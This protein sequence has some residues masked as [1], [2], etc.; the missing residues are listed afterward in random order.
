MSNEDVMKH[1]LVPLILFLRDMESK[2]LKIDT[3]YDIGAF[4]GNW[5]INIKTNVYRQAEFILFEANQAYK[6]TLEKTGFRHFMGVLSNEGRESVDFY[7]GT[8]TGDSYYKENTKWYENQSSITVP[9]ITLD[10]LIKEQN[11]PIPQLIK[12]DTQGSELDI[13]S[14]AKS[15]IG[16]TDLIYIECP[17]IEYN[18]GAPTITQ[19]LEFFRDNGYIPVDLLEI[20]KNEHTLIQVDI[21]FMLKESKE[22][23]LMKNE[24]VKI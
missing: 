24:F 11:L 21:M 8:N 10:A 18:S 2:G 20:H 17:I 6:A 15:C 22:K 14:G 1:P 16:K 5:S 19:Y 3:V 13:L 7:N 9:C 4:N 23:Y 12:I